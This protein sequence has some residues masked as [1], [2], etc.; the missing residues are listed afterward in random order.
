MGIGNRNAQHSFAQ[1]PEVNIGRS[2]FDLSF[3]VKDTYFFDDLNPVFFKEVIPGDTWN[4]SL[5]SFMRLATPKVPVLD[6]MY[7]DFFF[8]FVPNRIVFDKWE[9]LNG[10]QDNPDDST[11][12]IMPQMTFPAGGPEVGTIYDHFGLVTDVTGALS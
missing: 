11:D 1:I 12:F 5:S 3:T 10:A 7:V 6:N 4:C 8:F 2:K 9:Q